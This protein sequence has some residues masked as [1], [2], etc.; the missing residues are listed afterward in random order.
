MGSPAAR[1]YQWIESESGLEELAGCLANAGEFALDTESDGFHHYFDKLCL[2]QISTR[3]RDY[4]VDTLNVPS[5]L[6]LRPLLEDAGIC[7]VLHAAEQDLMYLNRDHGI[8]VRGL[9]DS[10]IGAQL[11][12]HDRLGLAA[13]LEEYFG[14]LL[15]KSNQLDDWSRRPLTDQQ[16]RYA[17]SDTDR[18]LP[19]K[20]RLVPALREKGRLEWVEEECRVL[21]ERTGA[22]ERSGPDDLTRFKGWTD[23]SPRG[24]AILRELAR[25]RDRMARRRDRPP[26]RIVGNAVLLAL[27]AR[28]PATAKEVMAAKGF[29]RQRGRSMADDLLA[30][31][32]RG[33]RMRPADFPG[34]PRRRERRTAPRRE[35]RYEIRLERLR[36]WRQETAK[37]LGLQP[38]V[39]TPQRELELLT[40]A[41]PQVPG[42]L[43]ALAGIRSW[44]KREF[45]REWLAILTQDT[46]LPGL[47]SG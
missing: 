10:L 5:L 30:A 36:E 6:P 4:V 8:T 21:E 28:P 32:Q 15:S 3:S 44:R 12:G 47:D 18:L 31:V 27:A 40:D 14:I 1:P 46:S 22:P 45:G 20:D 17:V 13:V 35:A 11:L 23:L 38:G 25:E 41:V 39:V 37:R 26:F 19:L 16:L 34:D 24:L 29:P 43:D 7:K 9:F 33:R 42:A 2:L